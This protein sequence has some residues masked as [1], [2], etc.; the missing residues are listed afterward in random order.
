MQGKNTG[1]LFRIHVLQNPCYYKQSAVEDNT[2]DRIS[3]Y[4]L[5]ISTNIALY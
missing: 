1:V 2:V 3:F 4:F 5:L